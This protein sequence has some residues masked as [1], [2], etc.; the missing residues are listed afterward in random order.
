VPEQSYAVDASGKRFL[1]VQREDQRD[2]GPQ[3]VEVI[4]N[5]FDEIRRRS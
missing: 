5:W 1:V 2:L 4:L 3:G